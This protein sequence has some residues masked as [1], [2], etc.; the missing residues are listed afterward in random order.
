MGK[1]TKTIDGKPN[2]GTTLGTALDITPT[3]GTEHEP[4]PRITPDDPSGLMHPVSAVHPE[5]ASAKIDS[6]T[7]PS[8]ADVATD[9]LADKQTVVIVKE[10]PA[11]KKGPSEFPP[12]MEVFK[13]RLVPIGDSGLFFISGSRDLC[14]NIDGIGAV[15][16]RQ[17]ND[18]HFEVQTTSTQSHLLTL[19]KIPSKPQWQKHSQ[20]LPASDKGWDVQIPLHLQTVR[21]TQLIIPKKHADTL[22]AADADGIRHDSTGRKY[23]DLESLGTV[24]VATLEK[25][26]LQAM[27]G[28]LLTP[29]GPRLQRIEGSTRWR[30][31]P[32][33]VSSTKT[34]SDPQNEAA[35]SSAKRPRLDD[36][37]AVPLLNPHLW[38]TWGNQRPHPEGCIRIGN[39]YYRTLPGVSE[40]TA[41]I[42]YAQWPDS[43]DYF[44]SILASK[45]WLQP[46]KAVAITRASLYPILAPATP[47]PLGWN[48]TGPLF[49][50]PIA[51]SV[52]AA[53]PNLSAASSLSVARALFERANPRNLLTSHGLQVVA[54][55]LERWSSPTASSTGDVASRFPISPRELSDPLR[56]LPVTP[57]VHV[58]DQATMALAP[59]DSG[60]APA[61]LD[62]LSTEPTTGLSMSEIFSKIL[63]RSGYEV[64]PLSDSKGNEVAFRR[65]QQLYHLTIH[66]TRTASIE[67]KAADV[68][69]ANFASGLLAD[70]RDALAVAHA[71]DE[72]IWLSGGVEMEKLSTPS[73]FIIRRP[74]PAKV[75]EAT[76]T[77]EP[78]R[79]SRPSPQES[80]TVDNQ[81]HRVLPTNAELD[82]GIVYTYEADHPVSNFQAFEE[83]LIL[84][85]QHQPRGA[86]R[87]PPDN[88]WVIDPRLPFE[89]PLT[90]SVFKQL[91]E[92]S[93]EAIKRVAKTQFVL[94]NGSD[95]TTG[96]GLTALRQAIHDSS[97]PGPF[98][99]PELCDPL[100]M[101]P[102][103]AVTAQPTGKG[104]MLTLPAQTT[105]ELLRLDFHPNYFRTEMD[106]YYARPGGLNL[107]KL[108]AGVL[109]RNGYS[110]F[111]PTLTHGWPTLVF[112]RDGH[113]SVYFLS[114][115]RV[116]GDTI[117]LLA[118]PD[119][120][121]GIPLNDRVNEDAAKAVRDADSLG[122]IV[123]LKGGLQVSGTQDLVFIVRDDMRMF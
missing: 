25:G 42:H 4:P 99:R 20:S 87:V 81:Q 58:D 115:Y 14:A 46:V 121:T 17:N 89:R 69:S 7:E 98:R 73:V 113:D 114:V 21:L 29:N 76:P 56:L 111:E 82:S 26:G 67:Y 106:A 34:A 64:F 122:K 97:E 117:E 43:F 119:P 88:H 47:S 109:T 32:E 13:G 80:I 95:R 101:L 18:G 2:P 92:L 9:P 100:L 31:R 11:V 12:D 118:L 71:R 86:T 22:S 16:V 75:I 27:S 96:A 49:E 66:V 40:N 15:R 51:Q 38:L 48:V 50:R 23:V 6:A 74:A 116:N 65:E 107:K 53:F 94:A 112:T 10:I 33:N 62:L 91:P 70:T 35:S 68:E 36:T 123:W 72:L 1:T 78:A 120:V 61:R 57:V 28:R 24:M 3:L 93:T 30:E 5:I 85:P 8:R 110:V 59:V 108:M 77:V 83:L 102:S 39:L 84:T 41:M 44:E 55:T 63:T 103:L 45:P 79:A 54:A 37:V 105:Q 52:A 104:R 60:Q 19:K 90:L